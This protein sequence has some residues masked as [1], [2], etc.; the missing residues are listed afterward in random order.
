V[1]AVAIDAAGAV[2]ATGSTDRTIKIWRFDNI[3]AVGASD[4]HAGAVVSLLFSADG[5]MCGSGGGDGRIKIRDVASGR[6][7]R[8]IDTNSAPVRSLAFSADGSCVLSVGVDDQAWLW[9]VDDGASTWIPIRH[10]APID[11]CTLSATA[12]YMV[13]ACSDRFVY[14]WDVPSGGLVEKY[15]TRRLFDHLIEPSPRRQERAESDDLRDEYLAGERIFHVNV[16]RISDDGSRIIL[17]GFV[18]DSGG[19]RTQSPH[20]PSEGGALLVFD[21][22][23]GAINTVPTPQA[24]RV[25]AVAVDALGTRLLWARANHHLELWDLETEECI[26]TLRGHSE[27]VNAVAFTPEGYAVSCSRDRSFRVWHLATGECV[28]SFVADAA[29]RSLAVAP[30]GTFGVGDVA[31]RV[32]F[33]RL[34][35]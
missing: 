1:T 18:P 25:S 33:L 14:L 20:D 32:H 2:G 16:A 12:R 29:L 24:E 5:R 26:R 11:S 30:D 34:V 27:K 28:A 7:L 3:R 10:S 23:S 22:L 31:G 17:S 15:G 21:P 6:V 4:A 19:I 13:T 8:T 35:N 9:T